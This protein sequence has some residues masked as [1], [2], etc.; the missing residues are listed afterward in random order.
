MKDKKSYSPV[1]VRIKE[2]L[3]SGKK[4]FV[5][6]FV[7]FGLGIILNRLDYIENYISRRNNDMITFCMALAPLF[8][9]IGYISGVGIAMKVFNYLYR[10]NETD[11]VFSL[12]MTSSQRFI[13]DF[14]SGLI[15]YIVPYII[16]CIISIVM[17]PIMETVCSIEIIGVMVEWRDII[18][19]LLVLL[20]SM[21]MFYA[22]A[23]LVCV[24]CGSFIQNF[25]FIILMNIS[26]PLL[27]YSLDLAMFLPLYRY[28]Y[29]GSPFLLYETSPLGGVIFINVLSN[30]FEWGMVYSVVISVI[31]YISYRIYKKRKAEDT[32]NAIVFSRFYYMLISV[33]LVCICSISAFQEFYISGIVICII[34]FLVFELIRKQRNIKIKKKSVI[35]CASVIAFTFI[36]IFTSH[37]T[38]GFGIIKKVPKLQSIEF[39]EL[40]EIGTVIENCDCEKYG[41]EKFFSD[42]SKSL[43]RDF[44]KNIVD[45]YFDGESIEEETYFY[46]IEISYRYKNGKSLTRRYDVPIR[47]YD[48]F[49]CKI[50]K[51]EEYME[52][53]CKDFEKHIESYESVLI[54][55]RDLDSKFDSL[56]NDRT[57]L[58]TDELRK[59]LSESYRND[60]INADA[61]S[62]ITSHSGNYYLNNIIIPY[63]FTETIEILD[64]I[65]NSDYE[66]E[67]KNG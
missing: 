32:G 50:V 22:Y 55:K 2:N 15:I 18:S 34:V 46:Y 61:N 1:S 42:D 14:L 24:C 45:Y 26:V 37:K 23:V 4:D 56:Q 67:M 12:P 58:Y 65:I 10:K 31:V 57:I 33:V 59:E 27:V 8:S 11:K 47:M 53:R 3:K 52:N 39:I 30:V 28:G 5:F 40:Q 6:L 25:I 35:Y 29:L 13:S 21:I 43:I 17:I 49:L 62:F 38:N 16:V 7:F 51:S 36:L 44:H 48:E 20:M 66:E 64:R 9:A 41:Y 54:S 63:S 60:I 19:H